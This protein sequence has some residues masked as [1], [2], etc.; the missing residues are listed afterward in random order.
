M[1]FITTTMYSSLAL[2]IKTDDKYPLPQYAHVFYEINDNNYWLF[3]MHQF[4][5]IAYDGF[6]SISIDVLIV[7]FII[8]AYEQLKLLE[9]RIEKLPDMIKKYLIDNPNE[10]RLNVE[11][12]FLSK[13]ID[14]HQMIFE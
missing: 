8:C 2:L 3:F 9:G 13:I 5:A 14:Q 10:K 4:I 12:R 7:G 1:G 6:W 11:I